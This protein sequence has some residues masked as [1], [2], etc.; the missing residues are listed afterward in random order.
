M[1]C[2][3]T[4]EISPLRTSPRM[5]I[6]LVTAIYFISPVLFLSHLYLTRF[7][8][9]LIFLAFFLDKGHDQTSGHI[10]LFL[11]SPVLFLSHLYLTRL[12]FTTVQW[13]RKHVFPARS[14]R[15]QKD[16]SFIL[17]KHNVTMLE[18]FQDFLCDLAIK[19]HLHLVEMISCLL[20]ISGL[21]TLQK[22]VIF[23]EDKSIFTIK[24]TLLIYS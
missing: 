13:G 10:D 5:E 22:L 6:P 24:T 19:P 21:Q 7:F 23:L 12:F 16:P 15:S 8:F 9:Q 2:W 3:V 14:E 11:I 4:L 1:S 20:L 17:F 18:S